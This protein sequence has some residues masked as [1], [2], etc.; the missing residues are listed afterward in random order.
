MVPLYG[1]KRALHAGAAC[2]ATASLMLCHAAV[3]NT[4]LKQ[5]LGAEAPGDIDAAAS[6]PAVST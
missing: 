5:C 2:G 6:D 3:T 4:V 1:H